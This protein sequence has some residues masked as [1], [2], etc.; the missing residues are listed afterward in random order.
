MVSAMI[1]A[2]KR[3]PVVQDF[4]HLRDDVTTL[5]GWWRNRV[6]R[7]LLN[8][9]LTNLGTMLGVYIGGWAMIKTLLGS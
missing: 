9:F 2:W 5:G 3:K 6:S 8:F 1:E 7:V 4:A